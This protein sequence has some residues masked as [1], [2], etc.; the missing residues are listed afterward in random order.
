MS[1]SLRYLQIF[2]GKNSRKIPPIDFN[3]SEISDIVALV[4]NF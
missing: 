1:R 2:Q 3:K 4:Q